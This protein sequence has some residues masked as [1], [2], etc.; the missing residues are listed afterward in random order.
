MRLHYKYIFDKVGQINL[1]KVQTVKKV[2][3]HVE[4]K[5]SKKKLTYLLK[6]DNPKIDQLLED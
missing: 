4:G 2:E 1:L 5:D 6:V 3:M